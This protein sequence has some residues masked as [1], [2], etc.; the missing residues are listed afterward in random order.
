MGSTLIC[1]GLNGNT[2]ISLGQG[3]NFK[4]SLGAN[5][6]FRKH[7]INL[8]GNYSISKPDNFTN[9]YI[10]RQIFNPTREVSAIFDQSSVIKQDFLGVL[11]WIFAGVIV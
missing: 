10:N 1:G 3:K 2:N 7:K 11:V 9:F 6:N 4:P 5:A 8:F